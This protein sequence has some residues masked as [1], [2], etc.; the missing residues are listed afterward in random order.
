MIIIS[1]VYKSILFIKG[2]MHDWQAED[3]VI[4]GSAI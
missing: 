4:Q 1:Y 3:Q 2:Q